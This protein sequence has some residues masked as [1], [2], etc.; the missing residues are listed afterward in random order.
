VKVDGRRV[1]IP[2]LLDAGLLAPRDVLVWDRPR[3]D[4][5]AALAELTELAGSLAG[6]GVDPRA[7]VSSSAKPS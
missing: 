1:Q 2:D 4:L 3:E 6:I 5:E 7:D